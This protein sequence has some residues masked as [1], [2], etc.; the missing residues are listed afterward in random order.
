MNHTPKTKIHGHDIR[1]HHETS[2][3][4]RGS[5]CDRKSLSAA[6]QHR[7]QPRRRKL[8]RLHALAAVGS[9]TSI[10]NM[11]VMFFTGT[12]VGAGV[13]I[14]RY[15]G[16]HDD[17]KLHIAVETTMAL[18]FICGILLTGLGIWV[19]PYMLEFMSTPEDVLP[20]ASVYLA[21]LFFRRVRSS[22]IQYGKCDPARGGR[23]ETS[24]YFLCLSSVMNIALDLLFV[25]G[26]GMAIEGV[27]YAT[28]ISQFISAALVLVV[29]SRSTENYRLTWRDLRIDKGIFKQ[30]LMIGLPTGFQQSLTS[31]SNDVCPVLHQHLRFE[32][33]GRMEQLFEDRPVR[34]SSD[35]EYRSGFHDLHE[36]EPRCRKPSK[37]QKVPVSRC[38]SLSLSRSQ[39][40]PSSS[41]SPR[42]L[43]RSLTRSRMWS[44]T[45]PCFSG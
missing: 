33:Y 19:T 21:N 31:F 15:Y 18:T 28:I 6:L 40:P 22:C 25:V 20:S 10:I 32:L 43:S 27:A 29:L 41:C 16:A 23:Y 45:E 17:E 9:T 1:F 11:I 12:S 4:V 5:A 38:A 14:S 7:R 36:S 44:A 8:R 42:A 30:I 24:L 39:A 34:L 3:H 13:V 35:A 26:F 37:G 2:H